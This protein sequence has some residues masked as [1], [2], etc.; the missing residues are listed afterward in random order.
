MRSLFIIGNGFDL[1][2]KL[3]TS[4]EHFH[5][6]LRKTYPG[7]KDMSPSYN[8][9]STLMPDGEEV[10][11]ENEVAS[12]LIDII[13]KAEGYGDWK[14]FEASLGKLDLEE[15]LGDMA[16]WMDDENDDDDLWKS[17]YRNE[18]ASKHFYWVTIKIKDI[19]PKW[20]DSISLRGVKPKKS[21][22]NLIDR[23]N[24]IF[25]TFNYTRVLEDIY[26]AENVIHIH[27]EQGGS[28]VIGHAE[29]RDQEFHY[30]YIGSEEYLEM[31]HSAL[32]KNSESIIL[33]YSDFFEGL[34]DIDTIFS[35]GFSFS[36]VDLPYIMEIIRRIQTDN[37][38]W[39]LNS[40]DPEE[41]R[42]EY[43][44]KIKSCGF[45]GKFAIF[46]VNQ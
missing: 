20:I 39:Y 12:F 2:H 32:R 23:E 10:Y 25:L 29:H 35:Y 14:D 1:D 40:Y 30:R 46:T 11:D 27:G 4:Y 22:K 17:A 36:D 21:F 3:P 7:A 44:D 8:I 15:Y 33:E 34:K 26:G 28:I 9:S 16:Y 37:V 31:I 24:D 38:T 6:Y 45:K 13:S 5:K 18:D 43:K 42:E 41:K 19:F